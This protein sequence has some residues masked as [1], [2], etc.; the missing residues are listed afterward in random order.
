MGTASPCHMRGDHH[1]EQRSPWKAP[2]HLESGTMRAL[3]KGPCLEGS[4][5]CHLDSDGLVLG[6]GDGAPLS[7]LPPNRHE[8]TQNK[9]LYVAGTYM[10]VTKCLPWLFNTTEPS[11][12]GSGAR[13]R[14]SAEIGLQHPGFHKGDAVKCTHRLAVSIRVTL[15]VLGAKVSHPGEGLLSCLC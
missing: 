8:L 4:I 9:S 13:I 14:P 7:G 11:Q 10:P 12:H 3:G 2:E 15:M 6:L 1:S 5:C